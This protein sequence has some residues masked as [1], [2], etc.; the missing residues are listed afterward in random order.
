MTLAKDRN[1]PERSG[2]RFVY[3]VKGA[4]RV[5]IGALVVLT[6]AGL[7]A[8]GTT[9][10]GLTT[11]GVAQSHADNRLGADGDMDVTVRRGIFRFDNS[12]GGDAISRTE[13]GDACY[14]VDDHTVAKTSNGGTRSPA[15]FVVDIDDVGVW[16]MVGYGPVVSPSG[17]LL[18]ANNLSDVASAATARGNIGANKLYLPAQISNLTGAG[19]AVARLVLPVDCTVT[20]LRSALDAPLTVGNATITA[21]IAGTPVTSGV[22]TITQAGS[23]AGDVDVATPTAANVG[24]AGQV[25]TLTVGGTNTAAVGA[26]VL[27]ELTY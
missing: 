9:A 2:D 26:S 4:T 5:F 14:I 23:A 20:K 18:A 1:S 7:A 25:L 19:A 16:L 13:I 22:L 27:V 3:P 10:T 12:A 17:S 8:G 11:V 21:T 6:T 15:G 24:T